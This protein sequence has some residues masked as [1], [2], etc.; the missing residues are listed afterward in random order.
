VKGNTVEE[1]GFVMAPFGEG[2]FIGKLGFEW[3][4]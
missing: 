1:V 3:E 4:V 2:K